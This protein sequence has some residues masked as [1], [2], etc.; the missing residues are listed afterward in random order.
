M[1]P[2][3]PHLGDNQPVSLRS[4]PLFKLSDN[5]R[6][7]RFH[8]Q[9]SIQ[10]KHSY[11]LL[12][13]NSSEDSAENMT[14]SS[15]SRRTKSALKIERER[16]FMTLHKSKYLKYFTSRIRSTAW[17][18][19]MRRTNS[20]HVPTPEMTDSNQRKTDTDIVVIEDL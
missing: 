15:F 13:F 16:G 8:C 19:E 7:A 18:K 20:E 1:A 3:P 4:V 6:G 14:I 17:T 9:V 10:I 12:T 11:H 2:E 5:K